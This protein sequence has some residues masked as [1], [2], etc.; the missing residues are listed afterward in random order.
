MYVLFLRVLLDDMELIR[1]LRIIMC[2]V[3]K[4][5]FWFWVMFFYLKKK[6][7]VCEWYLK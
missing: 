5:V 7:V 6:K 4:N 3:I 1:N 2:V